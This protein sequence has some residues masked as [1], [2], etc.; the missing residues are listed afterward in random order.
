[1]RET[2][3]WSKMKHENVQQL[4]GIIMFEGR[5]GMVSLWMENGDLEQYIQRNPRVDR[6]KLVSL[7]LVESEMTRIPTLHSVAT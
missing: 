4:L 1:M 2:Y 6:Y 5:L 7:L 3:N